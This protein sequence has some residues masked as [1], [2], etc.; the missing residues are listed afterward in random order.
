MDVLNKY[1]LMLVFLL[2]S[3]LSYAQ[4]AKIVDID[5]YVNVRKHGNIN[6]TIV[7]KFKSGEI[8]QMFSADNEPENWIGANGGQKHE[9]VGMVYHNRLK[10]LIAFTEI[11]LIESETDSEF[12]L[13]GSGVKIVVKIADFDYEKNQNKFTRYEGE[14]SLLEKYNG[15]KMW[16]TEGGEPNKYYTSIKI[17]WHGK[18]IV[19]PKKAYESMFQPNGKGY[20]F[21]Y[22]DEEANSLYLIG[23]NS[24]GSS[25]YKVLWVFKDGAYQYNNVYLFEDYYWYMY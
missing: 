10:E 25:N 22:Y 17:I 5:G 1:N 11:P 15:Q 7:G 4:L 6:S 24:D 9:L 19:F 21:C 16:G 8:V 20:T 12:V 2:S 13:S 23:Y 14:Y 18:E 3:V